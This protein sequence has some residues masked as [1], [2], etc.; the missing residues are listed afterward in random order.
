MRPSRLRPLGLLLLLAAVDPVATRGGVRD[1]VA[2]VTASPLADAA[3]R[4]AWGE[5]R[6]LLDRKVPVTP[7]QA[8]GM[9]A[10]HW[11]VHHDEA[12]IA[13]RLVR[14]GADVSATTRHGVTPLSLACTNGNATIAGVL[15]RAGAG[16]DVALPGG[17]TPL[18]TAARVGG[19]RGGR[20][21]NGYS[22]TRPTTRIAG[23]AARAPPV[24]GRC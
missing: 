15:L 14:A 9:T 10:L 12:A 20:T 5:V 2:A 24:A 1:E 7:A 8:D 17:E 11:A 21:E 6:A 23:H 18:M 16:V 4:A 19:R 3:E 13:Q 22:A